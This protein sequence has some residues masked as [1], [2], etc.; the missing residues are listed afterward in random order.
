MRKLVSIGGKTKVEGN[1][2]NKTLPPK[3]N[4]RKRDKTVQIKAEI[5]SRA[6]SNEH[7]ASIKHEDFRII[8]LESLRQ[9]IKSAC[10]GR[11]RSFSE[12]GI[13]EH[14]YSVENLSGK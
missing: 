12:K 11:K 10:M 5:C 13:C 1:A 7:S 3:R 4:D 2:G 9:D 14:K 8:S 6:H